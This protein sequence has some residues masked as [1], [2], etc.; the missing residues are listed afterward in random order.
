MKPR[1]L[2][3]QY[4]DNSNGVY[5]KVNESHTVVHCTR[6]DRLCC[7]MDRSNTCEHVEAVEDYLTDRV[8]SDSADHTP[9]QAAA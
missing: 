3:R 8:F 5:Y 2:V 1:L 7:L 4:A 6:G 9:A